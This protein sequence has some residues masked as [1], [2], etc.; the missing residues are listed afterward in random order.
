MEVASMED[1]VSVLVVDQN[2]IHLG[3]LANAALVL[4]LT[5]GRELPESTFGHDVV[6]GEG[7]THKYLTKIGHMVRKAGQS[8]IKTLR[9][10]LG[11]EADVRIIDYTDDA[12]P[13]D[14]EEYARNIGSHTK[15]QLNYRAI[16]IFGPHAKVNPLTKNLSRLE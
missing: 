16:H 9:D 5:A 10:T 11:E 6:D 7:S 3:I 12:A 14:Y 13:A 4:G 1:F 2:L 8:K 15:E